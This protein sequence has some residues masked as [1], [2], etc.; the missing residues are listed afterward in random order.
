M[1]SFLASSSSFNLGIGETFLDTVRLEVPFLAVTVAFP[2]RLTFP[3]VEVEAVEGLC[4]FSGWASFLVVVEGGWTLVESTLVLRFLLP[5]LLEWPA[6]SPVTG[7]KFSLSKATRDPVALLE[8]VVELSDEDRVIMAFGR[9]ILDWGASLDTASW[10]T[11]NVR[12][13]MLGQIDTR[14]EWIK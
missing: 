2:Y 3:L 6:R 10:K 13:D 1:R 9:V 4:F 11:V 7:W 5:A 14:L 12:R 8:V